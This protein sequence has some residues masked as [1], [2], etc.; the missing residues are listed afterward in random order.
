MKKEKNVNYYPGRKR[1]PYVFEKMIK[2]KRIARCFSTLAAA[3][4]FSKKFFANPPA[5][6]NDALYFDA[7]ARATYAKIKGIC[8]DFDPIEA[9]LFWKRHGRP[10][11]VSVPGVAECFS[12]FIEWQKASGRSHGHIRELVLAGKK[13][14]SKFS[15]KNLYDID[16][17]DLQNW[18]LSFSDLAPRS[19]QNLWTNTRNFLSW[20]KSARGWISRVPEIDTRLLPRTECK[21]VEIWSVREAEFAMRFIEQNYPAF[22]P[23]YALRLFAGLRTSEARK[24]RWEWID[25]EKRTILVPARDKD[26]SRVCQTGDDWLILPT[27]LPDNGE[28]VFSWLA[29]YRNDELGDRVPAPYTKAKVKISKSCNWKQNVMRHTFATMLASYNHDDGKTIL[30]T[31]HTNTQTL[32]RYYKGVN[33]TIG[34]STAFFSLHPDNRQL[35][36][37]I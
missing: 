30:A 26:G 23:H 20:C 28:T 16:E 29:R 1:Q 7:S 5:T 14:S 31:R 4:A 2:G 22:A 18:L 36:F 37:K 21:S 15:G 11:A 33:Q 10:K 24:M 17:R 27:F 35:E 25:F 13:F 32:K 12:A 9:V 8:G 34:E 19:I 6:E 3:N